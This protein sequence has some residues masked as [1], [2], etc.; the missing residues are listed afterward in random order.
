MRHLGIREK[1]NPVAEYSHIAIRSQLHLLEDMKMSIYEMTDVGVCLQV[2]SRE[3]LHV[4]KKRMPV[5]T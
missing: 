1:R 4:F 5:Q 3:I 2:F